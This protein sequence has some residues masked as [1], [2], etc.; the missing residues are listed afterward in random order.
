DPSDQGADVGRFW[1]QSSN[2]DAEIAKWLSTRNFR[3]APSHGIDR[4]QINEVFVLGLGQTGSAAPGERT[5][6]FPGPE[7]KTL[8]AAYDV[9]KANEMPDALGLTQRDA[10]GYRL[11]N[12]GGGRLRRALTR[13]P[14]SRPHPVTPE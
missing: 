10:E 9:K 5:P 4:Q 14:G 2:K 1:N 8:H 11:R 6:Y 13:Y 3:I 12:D 7:Y